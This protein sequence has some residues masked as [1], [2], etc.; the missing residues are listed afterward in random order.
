L[1]QLVDNNHIYEIE[2]D[3]LDIKQ[4]KSRELDDVLAQF[5]ERGRERERERFGGRRRPPPYGA[6][7]RNKK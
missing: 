2:I 6:P 7:S 5:L 3:V 4:R 1:I